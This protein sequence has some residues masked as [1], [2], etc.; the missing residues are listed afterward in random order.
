MRRKRTP[1]R[2]L[3]LNLR[4]DQKLNRYG[5]RFVEELTSLTERDFVKYF[6]K[7]AFRDVKEGL[8]VI[9]KTFKPGRDIKSSIV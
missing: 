7:V 2:L 6:G 9:K 4:T 5:I 3:Q 1:L 8:S